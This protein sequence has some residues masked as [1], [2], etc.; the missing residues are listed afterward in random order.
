VPDVL[1]ATPLVQPG[2]EAEL[3]FTAPAVP[4]EY[5]LVCTFPGHWRVMRGML[6]VE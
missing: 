4:G 6:V 2:K 1:H 3:V 5:P